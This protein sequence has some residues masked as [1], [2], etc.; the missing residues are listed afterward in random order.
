MLT[1]ICATAIASVRWLRMEPFALPYMLVAAVVIRLAI[2][3]VLKCTSGFR[4]FLAGWSGTI[5]VLV[6]MILVGSARDDATHW[7]RDIV[8]GNGLLAVL[9]AFGV[10]SLTEMMLPRWRTVRETS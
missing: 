5:F 10:A 2:R 9:Y 7:I 8:D 3:R 4:D 1:A 6:L